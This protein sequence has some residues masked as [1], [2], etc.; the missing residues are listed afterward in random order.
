MSEFANMQDV[1]Y[2]TKN[3][4][5]I[6]YKFIAE[7]SCTLREGSISNGG[8]VGAPGWRH[9]LRFTSSAKNV[10]KSVLHLGD[11]LGNTYIKK[12]IY[13]YDPCHLHYHFQVVIRMLYILNIYFLFMTLRNTFSSLTKYPTC[14]FY[15]LFGKMYSGFT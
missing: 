1:D 14:N 2:K 10:G 3:E 6:G 9:L 4:I 15:E 11:V 12:G 13:E 5:N 8:C 7:H